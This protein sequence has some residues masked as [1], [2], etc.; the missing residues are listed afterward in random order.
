M[1]TNTE[2]IKK[3]RKQSKVILLV[4]PADTYN[5]SLLKFVKKIDKNKIC[6]VSINKGHS[7]LV[8]AFKSKKINLKNLFFIDCV[9]KTIFEPKE[10]HNC[11]FISSPKAITELSLAL[12]KLMDA[13]FP[14]ILVDSLSTLMI[15]HKSKTITKFIHHLINEARVNSDI[16]LTL[17]I[18][19][20]DRNTEL[21][22]KIEVLVD[23]V[24]KLK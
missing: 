19:D 23:E 8:E 6:Y 20:K 18:S 17:T 7:A 21:Y 16:Y 3:S 1:N 15:Y 2:K 24:I 9:T 22:S 11:V 4:V 12:N 10:E 13:S 14:S 5:Q